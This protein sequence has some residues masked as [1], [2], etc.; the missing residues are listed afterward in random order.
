[1][2]AFAA[3]V[4]LAAGDCLAC[5]V[6]LIGRTPCELGCVEPDASGVEDGSDEAPIS[7]VGVVN[8]LGSTEGV[9]LASETARARGEGET[10]AAGAWRP[11][12]PRDGDREGFG[13]GEGTGA[14]SCSAGL[15]FL[16]G[17]GVGVGLRKKRLSL[18]PSELSSSCVPRACAGTLIANVIAITIMKPVLVFTSYS[19]YN[20][21]VTSCNTALST[22]C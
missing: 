2:V 10:V 9:A 4:D 3:R 13:L 12:A 21:S 5:S 19:F 8:G 14:S 20:Q 22:Q 7:G 17:V 6:G 11:S 1:M 18:L 15:A 16:E